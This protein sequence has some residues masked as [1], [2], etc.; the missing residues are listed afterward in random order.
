VSVVIP[1]IG[2]ADVDRAVRSALDQTHPVLEVIVAADTSDDFSLMEHHKVRVL[3]VGPGV[4]GN[5]ARQRGIE[6]AVGEVVALLDDDDWW[7]PDKL[8]KQ[9]VAV[10]ARVGGDPGEHWLAT[11]RVL[12]VR[13]G[14]EDIV[15]PTVRYTGDEPLTHYLLRKK[16]PRGSHGFMQASSLLFPRSLA[17]EVPFDTGLRFHQDVSWLIDL[18]RAI[19]DL[20]VVQVWEPLTNYNATAGSVSKKIDPEASA[21]WAAERLADDRRTMGDFILTQSFGFARRRGSMPEMRRVIRLGTRFGRPGVSARVYVVVAM[22]KYAAG[23][24]LSR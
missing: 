23:R 20:A 11:T 6:A 24:L 5:G 10:E 8:E 19:P 16:S 21:H 18:T 15:F 12:M 9:L 14:G 4:G 1:T 13:G 7:E 2:R 17:I 3:R 22:L